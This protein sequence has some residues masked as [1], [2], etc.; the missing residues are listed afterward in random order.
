MPIEPELA[1][2]PRFR[3]PTGVE[4]KVF[5]LVAI[6]PAAETEGMSRGGRGDQ[7]VFV[8]FAGDTPRLHATADAIRA[9]LATLEPSELQAEDE[10]VQE[11]ASEGRVLTRTHRL[12]ERNRT[13]VER[14]KAAVLASQGKLACEAC[15]FDFAAVYGERGEGFIECHHTVP[16]RDL[17]PESRTRLDDLALLCSN[18][19]RMVHRR[20]PWLSVEQLRA[21]LG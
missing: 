12:R 17:Q 7:E 4:M 2:N 3:N 16:L 6:D 21:S 8:E 1:A 14:K 11:D 10:V 18:C 5:N 15:G 20:S 13:L 9:N 19:H